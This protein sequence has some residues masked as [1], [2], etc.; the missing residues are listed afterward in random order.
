M[1][2]LSIQSLKFRPPVQ[3]EFGYPPIDLSLP[4]EDR[5]KEN[6]QRD[7]QVAG[8][9]IIDVHFELQQ[10]D[11][12]G[13]NSVVTTALNPA[14]HSPAVE[15][16]WCGKILSDTE[17]RTKSKHEQRTI[18]FEKEAY[19]TALYKKFD[20]RLKSSTCI[21]RDVTCKLRIAPDDTAAIAKAVLSHF[22]D[23]YVMFLDAFVSNIC[24]D[25]MRKFLTAQITGLQ[26]LLD[27]PDDLNKTCW[28]TIATINS[29]TPHDTYKESIA[30]GS[31]DA[32]ATST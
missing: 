16:N 22:P 5:A 10:F 24:G 3:P 12:V 13:N 32:L 28:H 2:P 17:W 26:R 7:L 14:K 19:D 31:P 27:A 8:T 11:S 30:S 4:K 20:P 9:G 25:A 21:V 18:L 1:G 23:Q 29:N 6:L 15:A